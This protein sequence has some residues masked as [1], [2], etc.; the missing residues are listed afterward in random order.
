MIAETLQLKP[1]AQQLESMMK[2][3]GLLCDETVSDVKK[4][5]LT[6]KTVFDLV[7]S[8]EC[9][10]EV[11]KVSHTPAYKWLCVQYFN[12][13]E[14][15]SNVKLIKSAMI[16]MKEKNVSNKLIRSGLYAWTLVCREM[17]KNSDIGEDDSDDKGGKMNLTAPVSCTNL[18]LDEKILNRCLMLLNLTMSEA[19]IRKWIKQVRPQLECEN[20]ER[21][22]FEQ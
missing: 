15:F 19:L 5:R 20:I 3:R 14:T 11:P 16:L 2:D 7:D 1:F 4:T 10:A 18:P 21:K 12:S 9:Q 17:A 22:K 8:A 13:R 6:F